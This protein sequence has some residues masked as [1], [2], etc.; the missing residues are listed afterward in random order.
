VS[1][2]PCHGCHGTRRATFDGGF[3]GKCPDCLGK[4]RQDD[5]DRKANGILLAIAIAITV[6]VIVLPRLL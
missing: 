6:L 5:E 3:S 1:N 2:T 4:G